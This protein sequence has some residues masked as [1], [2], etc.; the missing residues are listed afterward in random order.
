MVYPA[1][2]TN[3]SASARPEWFRDLKSDLLAGRLKVL[4]PTNLNLAGAGAKVE[5]FVSVDEAGHWPARDWQIL[6]MNQ[7]AQGWDATVPVDYVDVPLIYFVRV[8]GLGDSGKPKTETAGSTPGG[9]GPATEAVSPM[10]IV[11]P[12]LLGMQEPTRIF[13][14]FLDGFEE[15][16]GH[17]SL[18]SDEAEGFA[19]KASPL[20]KT[21]LAALEISLPGNKRSV[22]VATTRIRG[23]Q[24]QQQN[25]T[26]IRLW[27][28]TAQGPARVR[29]TLL[30]HAFSPQQR[31]APGKRDVAINEAWQKVDLSFDDFKGAALGHLDLFTIDF[32]GDG[33]QQFLADDLQ[34]LGPWPV[35][36]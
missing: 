14:P 35:R 16:L 15:G 29:F 12:R 7:G 31:V 6:S 22:T 2:L 3:A 5:L 25:A 33:P 23:W 34:L 11:Q 13:W 21:G 27:L 20:A 24:V 9:R 26:G 30:S 1:A 28:R 32:I 8:T 4:W 17:W 10:R 19:M 36:E 18:L